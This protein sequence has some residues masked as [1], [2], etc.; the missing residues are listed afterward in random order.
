ME[1]HARS[2]LFLFGSGSLAQVGQK[3]ERNGFGAL[4][5]LHFRKHARGKFGIK[6]VALIFFMNTGQVDHVH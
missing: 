1:G 4:S 5:A 2:T 3:A 6:N